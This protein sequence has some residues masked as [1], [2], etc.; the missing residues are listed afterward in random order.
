MKRQWWLGLIATLLIACDLSG[1]AG[2]GRESDARRPVVD[3]YVARAAEQIQAPHVV[4]YRVAEWVQMRGRWIY[5]DIGYY[6]TGYGKDQIWFAGAGGDIVRS[7]R[8]DWEQEIY[9][10]QEAGPESANKRSL[11][12]W[13]VLDVRVRPRLT[14]ELDTYP[15]IP[16]DRAQRWGWDVDRMK[17]EWAANSHWRGGPGYAGGLCASRS[18]QHEPFLTVTRTTRLGSVEV[19]LER[20]H[21]GAHVQ[22]RYYLVHEE[23]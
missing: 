12:I 14:G 9:I 18:W 22:L 7:K 6:D 11:G 21:G 16:L 5:P 13:P 4:T 15:T 8:I 3:I 1:E 19:W 10:S 23:K 17:L 20:I 2:P